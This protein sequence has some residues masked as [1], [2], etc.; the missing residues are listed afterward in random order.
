MTPTAPTTPA[1]RCAGPDDAARLA[2][3]AESSFVD[4][5]GADNRAEDMAAYIATA[6]GEAIQ[7]AELEDARCCVFLAEQNGEAL[8]YA[9]LREG[10]APA[11]VGSARAVEV[12]R[13][14]AVRRRIGAGVGAAL[15]QHC[16]RE[17]AARG[18]DALWLG[19][20][21]RNE[22]AIAF[23]E[24]WGFRRVGTQPFQLG[25]DLQT[26]HVMVRRTAA[27]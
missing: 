19:V 25:S 16:I 24:R 4:S 14:Y 11:C 1:I 12:A 6:F 23:Y 17:A 20:W 9:M 3:L 27:G 21:E 13:L 8:G 2:T 26:D 10:P 22:R 7:R 15:M 18:R 5:F